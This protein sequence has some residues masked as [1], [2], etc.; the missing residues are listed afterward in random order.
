MKRNFPYFVVA[1][2]VIGLIA[3]F[4]I[5][6]KGVNRSGDTPPPVEGISTLPSDDSASKTLKDINVSVYMENSGSMDGYVNLNS[7]FKDALGKII[8]KSN[9]FY[10]GVNLFFVNN[11]NI[12]D[13]QETQ[14][15]GDVNNFV[16]QLNSST[17]K[18]GNTASS[19][20]NEIFKSVLDHTSKDTVSILFSDFVYSISNNDV[21]SAISNAKNAT[22]GAFMDAIKK[23]PNFATIILQCQSSFNGMYYDRTDHGI[24]YTGVRP[25]Y[26]FIMGSYDNL[27]DVNKNLE[28]NTSTTGIPGLKN[29]YFLSTK[30]WNLDENTVQVITTDYTN[31]D[32]IKA[33][34]DGMNIDFIKTGE[35]NLQ[36]ALALGISNLFVDESYI[37]D[38]KNYKTDDAD[39]RIVKAERVKSSSVINEFP[40]FKTPYAIHISVPPSSQVPNLVIELENKI[41]SWV[42]ASSIADDLGAVP[43]SMQTFAIYDL[44]SGVY[45]AF[46]SQIKDKPIFK[47]EININKYK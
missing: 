15:K 19:N 23:D 36:Y 14:L 18:I 8:V 16:S 39:I 30:A 44:I 33:E 25:F 38:A 9:S 17:M 5:N 40:Q 47:F 26:I 4:I 10:S 22:M 43:E 46:H 28:L 29:K 35:G 34:K 1:A 45:D 31:S 42:Q 3:Y 7:E 37:C 13:V 24:P 32:M 27:I 12:Y 11:S 20:I 21:S 2:I 41:P 6:A